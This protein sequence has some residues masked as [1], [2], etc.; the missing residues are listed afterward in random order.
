MELKIIISDEA[1]ADLEKIV[2]F[3]AVDNPKLARD[4]GYKLIA[5]TRPLARHPKIGRIVPE[6]HDV[7]IREL[8]FGSYRIPYRIKESARRIEILRFWHAARGI[9]KME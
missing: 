8:I 6:F 2:S 1:T 4:F 7:F 9:P 3:I 5:A